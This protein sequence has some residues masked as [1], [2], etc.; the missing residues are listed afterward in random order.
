MVWFFLVSK[1]P[2]DRSQRNSVVLWK[3]ERWPIIRNRNLVFYSQYTQISSSSYDNGPNVSCSTHSVCLVV[4]YVYVLTF[5]EKSSLFKSLP[6]KRVFYC[7]QMW[8]IYVSLPQASCRGWFPE[9]A[10]SC[11]DDCRCGRDAKPVA[12]PSSCS[13]VS[14]LVV[15]PSC[16]KTAR[17]SFL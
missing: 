12:E 3:N 7:D 4:S 17:F 11:A 15:P 14:W 1:C 10:V 6:K 2:N 13:R 8:T 5:K 9:L 16:P